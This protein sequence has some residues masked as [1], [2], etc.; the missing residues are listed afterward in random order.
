MPIKLEGYI[1]D[2][3]HS[4]FSNGR[5]LDST[6]KIEDMFKEAVQLG[7]KGMALTDHEIVSGHIR[8]IQ[9]VRK[10]KEKG[11][12]PEDFKLIL[13]NEIY[14]VDSLEKV[15]D[16]YQGGGIT[17]F[18]HFLLLAKDKVGHE[19]MRILSSKAWGN[20]F[21]TGT[22]IRVP[23][24]KNELEEVIGD[25]KG[26]LI[27]STACLGSESSI[28]LLRIKE[29]EQQGN[30]EQA[31]GERQKLDQ[32]LLW[33][34][35][36]FGKDNFFIELQPAISDEQKYV[37]SKLIP[38]ADFYGLK[39]IITTDSHYL[40]PEDREIHHAFLNAK[41]GDRETDSFYHDTYMHSIDEIY[42]K[43]EDYIDKDII[44]DALNNT[45]EIG[46]MVEDYTI[47]KP[48][49]VPKVAL[50]EFK[51]KHMLKPVYEKYSYIKKMAYSKH[52]QDQFAVHLIEDGVINKL[53]ANVLS[54]ERFHQYLDRINTEL[55]E[56]WKISEKLNQRMV[57][58]YVTVREIVNVIW[59]DCGGNSLV[60]SGRGSASGFLLNFLFGITNIDPLSYGI[61][62]PYWRHLSSTRPDVDA[63][64]IDIDTEG[65]KRPHIL[66]ALREHFG[67]DKMLR[68]A[69]FGTETPK[70]AILTA[71]RGLGYDN[72]DMSYLASLIPIERGKARPLKDCFFGNEENNIKPI[73]E[74]VNGCVG[75]PHL[76]ET[77]L[78]LDGL[79]DKIGIHA[80]GVILY[81]QP[82]YKTSAL[83]KAPN[84]DDI[85]QFDLNDEHAV[86]STKFD[87]LSI[88]ALDKMRAE[89]D[90]LL[91]Y[92]EITWQGSLRKTFDYYL[93][94]SKLEVKDPKIWDMLGNGQIMDLFQFSTYVG[95]ESVV[96]VKPRSLL[97]MASANSLMRLMA[98]EGEQ[99]IDTYIK[100][101]NNIELWYQDMRDAGLNDEDIGIMKEHL[102][103]TYGVADT[104]E[105]IML[106]VMDKRISGFDVANS[107][108]LRKAVAKKD[109]KKLAK[110]KSDYIVGCNNLGT[111]DKLRDYVWDVQIMRQA[112][113]SF[114][115][116][117]TI[118]Y[119][120]VALQELNLNYKFDPLYWQTACLTVNSGSN[121][122][123]EEGNYSNKTTDY[124][125]VASAIGNIRHNG[126]KVE[127]P[128]IN[129]ADFGFK[130]DLENHSIVYGLKS[131]AGI[132]DEVVHE[133]ITHQHFNSM[134]DFLNGM[135][136]TKKLQKKH[137]LQLIKAGCFDSFGD[138]KE[139]MKQFIEMLAEPKEKLTMANL[140]SVINENLVPDNLH[141]LVRLFRFK[142]YIS[143]NKFL[144]KVIKKPK[145]KWIKLDIISM[146]Y[147]SNTFEDEDIKQ[148]QA[149]ISDDGTMVISEKQFK[150]V[151]DKHMQPIKDWLATDEALEVYNDRLIKNE[152][153]NNCSGTISHWEMESI[154]MYFHEHELAHVTKERYDIKNFFEQ[155]TEP[156][157]GKPYKWKGKQMYQYEI[158]RIAGT[159]LDKD[160]NRHTITLLTNE[161]VVNVRVY[162]GLFSYFAKQISKSVNG[163]KQV[164][165]PS[166]FK[167]GTMLL[168]TGFR[169]GDN[170]IPKKYKDSVY[171]HVIERID[172]IDDKGRLT[173]TANRPQV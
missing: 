132:N 30:I 79:I 169:S 92:K 4:D 119:S 13:G 52:E 96:K 148:I 100:Y 156:V 19:Q 121:E 72:D 51:V 89:L 95:R 115:V 33:C 55:G 69:T 86:G 7:Y 162:A 93:H 66:Q 164:I 61:E 114:S 53:H 104:Q 133:I 135:Y 143:S 123:L 125:K 42:Q 107:N 15:R 29:Y 21:R 74:L 140:A 105:S 70:N 108:F 117:H 112:G 157:K 59:D 2:H 145:D 20:S 65:N 146:D 39:R 45:V 131:I 147:V 113:Y 37:N 109:P 106:L 99:P 101:K 73:K 41:E 17:K 36:M 144:Y 129:K 139:I 141:D 32:F 166:W 40:R 159:V 64:D 54:R 160:K 163:K 173:L 165:D 78:K 170:F 9:T 130:P 111:H 62:M 116:L 75:F 103:P 5:L 83:M 122:E 16:N 12:M 136:E 71:G 35:R 77:A 63:L 11:D 154:S 126:V 158:Y 168:I 34:M 48:Q 47:E 80:G 137:V 44:T 1:S 124:G 110:V 3:N 56:I 50:P 27:A 128:D 127:L 118:A 68:V 6:D 97:E 152:W 10:M 25:N 91:Q 102:L 31:D 167:K 138:R 151:Y 155:P 76:Q 134:Y 14:L 171:Q 149:E 38:L 26:H 161:G 90:L 46:N 85:C 120:T 60:G 58:Y 172:K 153:N 142:K 81:N 67:K 57:S 82:Y 28:R 88:E 18:P 23:T 8:A 94:P 22:M 43:M 49:V 150:K 87:L 24:V 84:G 98:A